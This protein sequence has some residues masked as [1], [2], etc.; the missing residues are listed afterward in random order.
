[1]LTCRVR[2][3]LEDF[4]EIR[5][6]TGTVDAVSGLKSMVLGR[7]R[8]TMKVDIALTLYCTIKVLFGI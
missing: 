2:G 1:M 4:L 3:K 6:A 8:D 5:E 7:K